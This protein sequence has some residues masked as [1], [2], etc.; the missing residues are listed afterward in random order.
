MQIFDPDTGAADR[1]TDQKNSV[2]RNFIIMC[3]PLLK[4]MRNKF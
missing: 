3:L 4:I 2:K 1:G